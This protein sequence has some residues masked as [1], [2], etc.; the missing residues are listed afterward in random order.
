MN[1]V[2]NGANLAIPFQFLLGSIHLRFFLALFQ[3]HL[4]ADQ[5]AGIFLVLFQSRAL[6]PAFQKHSN[7]SALRY[8]LL[9]ADF[10][11]ERIEFGSDLSDLITCWMAVSIARVAPGHQHTLPRFFV[12][13]DNIVHSLLGGKPLSLAL[14]D[15]LHVTAALGDEI[16]EI[17]HDRGLDGKSESSSSGGVKT[18]KSARRSGGLLNPDIPANLQQNDSLT[19]QDIKI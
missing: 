15:L 16:V 13:S 1:V 9:L 4:L 11:H 6:V 3:I 14:L 17:E 12:Q 10:L 8:L 5:L 7:L 2:P 18:K 19:G